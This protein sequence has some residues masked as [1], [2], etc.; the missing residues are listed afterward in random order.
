ME[1]NLQPGVSHLYQQTA[2][3][4]NWEKP[5]P[6]QIAQSLNKAHAVNKAVTKNLDDALFALIDARDQIKKLRFWLKVLWGAL[7]ISW[8]VTGYVIKLLLPFA[9]KGMSR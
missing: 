6:E 5:T 4:N 3:R 1:V 7:G 8:T 9:V 2:D